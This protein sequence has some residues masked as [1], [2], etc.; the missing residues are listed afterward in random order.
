MVARVCNRPF[1]DLRHT[2]PP[3]G[4]ATAKRVTG[5]RVG[6]IKRNLFGDTVDSKRLKQFVDHHIAS[7]NEEKRRRWNFDFAAGRPEES[8]SYQWEPVAPVR[9]EAQSPPSAMITLTRAAHVIPATRQLQRDTSCDSLAME[10]LMDDRAERA[11]RAV[12]AQHSDPEES[13]RTYPNLAGTTTTSC[14]A[15]TPPSSSSCSS[16][17]AAEIKQPQITEYFKKCKRLSVPSQ[18]KKVRRVVSEATP[19]PPPAAVSRR[20]SVPSTSSD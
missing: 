4:V 1:Q 3:L 12:E 8:G 13:I 20:H 17:T 19:P 2:P 15:T 18:A 6:H 16:T 11:N 14:E 7:E 10:E 9:P 5:G